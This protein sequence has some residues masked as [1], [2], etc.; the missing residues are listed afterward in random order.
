[1]RGVHHLARVLGM[2][3]PMKHAGRDGLAVAKMFGYR[4][5]RCWCGNKQETHVKL[6]IIVDFHVDE[7]ELE[8][9]LQGRAGEG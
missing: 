7:T 2:H 1:M 8:E 3:E 6:D 9:S 5:A 4:V